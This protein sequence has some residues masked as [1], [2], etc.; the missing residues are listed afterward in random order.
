MIKSVNDHREYS[1]TPFLVINGVSFRFSYPTNSQE[2]KW[3]IE[4]G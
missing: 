3:I 2:N 1:F 4:Q